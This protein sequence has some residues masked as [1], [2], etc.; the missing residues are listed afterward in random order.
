MHWSIIRKSGHFK[1]LLRKNSTNFGNQQKNYCAFLQS[2]QNLGKY[3]SVGCRNSGNFVTQRPKI[4]YFR[5]RLQVSLTVVDQW[6]K[7]SFIL[8]KRLQKNNHIFQKSAA[9]NIACISI[10]RYIE[11]AFL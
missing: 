10:N 11:N 1:N 4:A 9:K 3:W 2:P 8:E 5:K 7:L 6:G